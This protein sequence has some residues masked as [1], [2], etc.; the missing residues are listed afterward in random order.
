M[1]NDNISVTLFKYLQYLKIP[2][3]K[4]SVIQELE[5]H[6]DSNSLFAISEVLEYWNVAHEAFKIQEDTLD[7]IPVPFIVFLD[8]NDGEFAVVNEVDERFVTLSNDK[9]NK[10]KMP[11]A[12]FKS[13]FNSTILIAEKTEGAGLQDYKEKKRQ[14]LINQYRVPFVI[15][16]ALLL[17]LLSL[18]IQLSYLKSI[19]APVAILTLLKAAGVIISILL[20]IQSVDSNDPLISRLCKIGKKSNCNTI[21][22][23]PA[24]NLIKG[25]SWS[26][27]G[28]CYFTGTFLLLIF[29]STSPVIMSSLALFNLLC[30]PYTFYSIYYQW[31]IAKVWCP[32]CCS[33]QAIFWLEFFVFLPVQKSLSQLQLITMADVSTL[34]ICFVLPSLL[35]IFIKPLALKANELVSVKNDLVTFKYQRDLFEYR[36]SNQAQYRLLDRKDSIILGNSSL[37]KVITMVSNPYCA[38]CKKAHVT[39]DELISVKDN[40]T[41]Q[42]VF[43]EG[44]IV[45]DPERK[46]VK[47]FLGLSNTVENMALPIKHWY[48]TRGDK[49]NALTRSFP[50]ADLDSTQEIL[51]NQSNW[52]D[53]TNIV[54]TP[55]IFINGRR[56]PHGYQI[57]D[58]KYLI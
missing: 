7:D 44:D 21:L 49:Y 54:A 48:H 56:L 32:F 6:P 29:N 35:W 39:L 36:L 55:T 40:V 24:A 18:N 53:R 46:A 4:S 26:E 3:T 37:E 38:A 17:L 25:I 16:V 2:I 42:V 8:Q 1:I 33:I 9:W 23:S 51:D 34:I 11:R 31:K 41:L 43:S 28:F 30:L 52:C 13:L 27:V 45:I 20:L 57:E 10:Y 47:Y 12:T 15:T 5:R 22:S 58:L 50:G 14:E 19:T